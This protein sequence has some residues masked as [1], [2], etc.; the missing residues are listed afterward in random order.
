M[1]ELL[2]FLGAITGATFVI[3]FI[4]GMLLVVEHDADKEYLELS[5]NLDCDNLY[6]VILDKQDVYHYGL[7]SRALNQYNKE[8]K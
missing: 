8:C 5:L 7:E 6:N 2:K 3:L 1:I 4:C